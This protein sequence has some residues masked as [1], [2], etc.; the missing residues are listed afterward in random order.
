MGVW[1]CK[2]ISA[3]LGSHN[4][5][6]PHCN[7]R[8][9]MPGP[10]P[11][12]A[13]QQRLGMRHTCQKE[14]G[15]RSYAQPEPTCRGPGDSNVTCRFCNKVFQSVQARKNHERYIVHTLFQATFWDTGDHRGGGKSTATHA[16]KTVK[17]LTLKSSPAK[18][19]RSWFPPSTPA[20]SLKSWLRKPSHGMR[21]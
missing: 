19:Y 7:F 17:S 2:S 6:S 18:Y 15:L 21:P 14:F 3:R 16:R 4:R 12:V 9:L 1:V 20:K 8:F 5:V 13:D 10:G 11:H